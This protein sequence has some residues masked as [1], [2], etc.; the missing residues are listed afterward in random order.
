MTALGKVRKALFGIRSERDVFNGRGFVP[1]AWLHFD[2]VAKSLVEG[3]HASLEDSRLEVLVPRLEAIKPPLRGFAY[4]GAGMGIAALDIMAPWKNRVE[5]FAGEGG[6]GAPHIYPIY[7]GVGLAVARLRRDPET[8][9]KRLDPLLGWV[10]VDG[11]GFHAAFFSWARAIE[12]KVTP[13]HFSHYALRLF[14]QGM[15][16]AIW[17]ASGAQVER[18]AAIIST[19]P[20]PRQ[21]ELWAGVGL[22]SSYA[23]GGEPGVLERVC[24]AAGPYRLQLAYGA[25]VAAQGRY[26]AGNMVAHTDVACETYCGLASEKVVQIADDART[27][28]PAAGA[29]PVHEVWRKRIRSQLALADCVGQA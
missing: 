28:L 26:T 17:F 3:Y 2:F 10:I 9:L 27:N 25:A 24:Q 22:A 11:Y 20:E 4:E 6:P 18:V 16:R 7:I 13:A 23:G 1:E 12:R 29:E 14:D 8:F 5:A 15:G 19:F 21:A